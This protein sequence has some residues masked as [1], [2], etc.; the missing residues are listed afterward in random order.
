MPLAQISIDPTQLADVIKAATSHSWEAGALVVF[1]ALVISFLV[2]LVKHVLASASTR[3]DRMAKRIDLLE[4]W[5]REVMATTLNQTRE[6]LDHNTEALN[7]L[8]ASMDERERTCQ[9][10]QVKMAEHVTRLGS[11]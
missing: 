7:R 8:Q 1:M 11:R 9:E 5:Q 10:I 4:A 6:A 3:E 2:W